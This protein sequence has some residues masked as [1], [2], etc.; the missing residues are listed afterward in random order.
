MPLPS[1]FP[2]ALIAGACL[3][4]LAACNRQ[5][6]RPAPPPPA[7]VVVTVRAEPV[8][9]I[10]ELPGRIQA[11][12]T[13]EVRARTDGIVERRL[14]TEGTDVRAGQPL[15]AIDPRDKRA[16]LQQ[17]R[18]AQQRAEAIRVN[19]EQVVARYQP[20]VAARS[21]SAQEYD[22]AVAALRQ[23]EAN[24]ADAKGAVARAELEVEYTTVLAPIA[25][26]VGRALVTEG[27]L[28]SAAGATLMTTIDQLDPIYATF[29]QANSDMMRLAEQ[30][31]AGEVDLPSLDAADVRL[32]LEDGTEYGPVG[33]LGFT[34]LQVDP[35]TGS[36]ILR[37]TFPNGSRTLLPGQFVR[38]RIHAGTIKAG[39]RV[40]QRAVQISNEEASVFVVGADQMVAPRPVELGAL[41]GADW[42]ILSGLKPGDRV[43]IDGWQKARPGQ[44]VN[45][46]ERQGG[47]QGPAAPPA[48]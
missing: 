19:A 26:R 28:V 5:P 37:A 17:A 40:P 14:Y 33:K 48:R 22:A 45:P 32:V 25:G 42:V 21:V 11:I 12:R 9:N 43:I 41:V 3:V 35:T 36:Q 39:V 20:L 29:T 6:E 44:K 4:A 8:P 30:V 15:F 27:A 18:A 10:I 47:R 38:G 34:D 24:V 31:R 16:A 23:A 13:S 2:R 46:S 7:V 1:D